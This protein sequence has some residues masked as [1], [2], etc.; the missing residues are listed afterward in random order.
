MRNTIAPG[1]DRF[2]VRNTIAP[3]EEYRAS[4]RSNVATC[5][6]VR[7]HGPRDRH[8]IHAIGTMATDAFLFWLCVSADAA[9][10]TRE[11]PALS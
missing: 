4:L 3:G 11:R 9:L 5:G 7:L 6:R 1:A 2:V 8:T 10:I